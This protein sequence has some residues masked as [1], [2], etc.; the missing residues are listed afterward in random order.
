MQ[1]S[2]FSGEKKTWLSFSWTDCDYGN[3]K[4]GSNY[5]DKNGT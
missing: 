4:N 1:N 3:Q 2:G 5:V